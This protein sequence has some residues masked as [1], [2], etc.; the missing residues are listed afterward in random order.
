MRAHGLGIITVENRW[1]N[2][3]VVSI[4]SQNEQQ[5]ITLA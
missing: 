1:E 2:G 5:V 3:R 4:Q